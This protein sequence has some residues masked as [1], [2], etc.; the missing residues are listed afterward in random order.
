MKGFDKK[1]IHKITKTFY[2]ENGYDID[3]FDVND[4][5]R[6]GTHKIEFIKTTASLDSWSKKQKLF[7]ETLKLPTVSIIALEL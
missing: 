2:D 4:Q 6:N 3:G 7:L 5:D 1:G